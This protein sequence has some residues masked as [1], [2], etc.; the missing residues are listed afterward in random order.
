MRN[1]PLCPHRAGSP[2]PP[3]QG[4]QVGAW[5]FR[6]LNSQWETWGGR[7]GSSGRAPTQQDTCRGAGC[8]G[9]K[10]AWGAP[11]G[12]P[13]ALFRATECSMSVE[14][15]ERGADRQA[16]G[17]TGC[18]AKT[19][20]GRPI[21]SHSCEGLQRP[22]GPPRTAGTCPLHTGRLASPVPRGRKGCWGSGEAGRQA[23][24]TQQPPHPGPGL[25]VGG[26]TLRV[27]VLCRARSWRRVTSS[28]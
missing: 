14:E 1:Y 10:E 20:H 5:T 13:S 11:G 28:C 19:A 4:T 26:L 3:H 6:L 18:T 17:V 22:T 23:G 21:P 12:C 16:K 2:A 7:R 25:A 9:R 15:T 24:P 27:A 8:I